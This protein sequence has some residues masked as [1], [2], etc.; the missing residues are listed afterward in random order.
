MQRMNYSFR[1]NPSFYETYLSSITQPFNHSIIHPKTK[2]VQFNMEHLYEVWPN[3]IQQIKENIQSLNPLNSTATKAL[4]LRLLQVILMGQREVVERLL[5]SGAKV[6]LKE[7]D[8]EYTPLHLASA[9]GTIHK[10][11][12]QERG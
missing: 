8:I 5:K 12:R 1:E 4:N 7:S 11:S 3:L 2:S 10:L 6:N 9:K